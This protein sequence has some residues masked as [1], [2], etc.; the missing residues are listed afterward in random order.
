MSGRRE[1]YR[2]QSFKPPPDPIPAYA[3]AGGGWEELPF[4][5]DALRAMA[6]KAQEFVARE[7]APLAATDETA[8]ED[9]A[10]EYVLRL[11]NGGW[12]KHAVRGEIRACALLRY[13]L[14]RASALADAMFAMQG[15]G[16]IPILVG[17]TEAQK[18]AWLPKI[19]DGAIAAFALTEENAGSDP[20]GMQLK[21]AKVD[22][23][24]RLDGEK[25]FISNAGIAEV[26]TVFARTAPGDRDAFTAFIVKGDSKRLK[27]RPIDVISPHPIG[28]LT[29]DS[30][31]VKDSERLSG[32]GDGLRIA[33]ATLDRFRPTVGAAACGMARRALEESV[34]RTKARQQFGK[35]LAAFQGIQ[36]MLA[37]MATELSAAEM[38]VA[39]AA[40]EADRGGNGLK[41]AAA[42]SKRFATDHAHAV[43]DRA[44]Q[45]HGGLGVTRGS[46]VERLYRDV[47]ALR[48]YEGTS[49][50]QRLVISRELTK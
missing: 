28:T 50:I 39:R 48:I 10:R 29:F 5:D 2:T 40:W 20:A 8:V 24:F 33:F 9:N 17:G 35:P 18:K 14:A 32:V 27:S 7:I 16:A 25:T 34:A 47:R 22:D 1:P 42:M 26:I 12:L 41:V 31:D 38:L 36:F 49:E 23:F 19:E 44:V 6:K 46:I 37:D 15:L 11:A 3:P 45:I 21:A 30:V 4:F 13:H 43:I